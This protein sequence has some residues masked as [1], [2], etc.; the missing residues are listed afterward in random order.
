MISKINKK[1][2]LYMILVYAIFFIFLAALTF[3]VGYT[4]FSIGND[5]MAIPFQD[6]A[7]DKTNYSDNITGAVVTVTEQYHNT[8][9]GFFDYG[10]LIGFSIVFI[11]G[12]VLSYRTRGLNYFNWLTGLFYVNMILLLL[13]SISLLYTNWL[14]DLVTSV[15][16]GLDIVLPIT[17]Y[18][19]E[20][21]GVIFLLQSCLYFLVN[22]IDFDFVTIRNRKKK[23]QQLLDEDEG[24]L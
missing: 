5:Y 20:H 8:N 19:L 7:L 14:L 21:L 17:T 22:V 4:L 16:P 1:G 24:I 18:I 13:L 9:L 6:L 11:I 23:E 10:F 2:Q 15:M 3:F 12:L